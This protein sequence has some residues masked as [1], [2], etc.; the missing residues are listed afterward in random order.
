MVELR[1]IVSEEQLWD[2]IFDIIFDNFDSGETMTKEQFY[3][4]L[5]SGETYDKVESR[6]EEMV[7]NYDPSSSKSTQTW[8]G[9]YRTGGYYP[10]A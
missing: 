7:N 9:K 1:D 3:E 6:I 8:K 10:D 5:D 2:I 4:I